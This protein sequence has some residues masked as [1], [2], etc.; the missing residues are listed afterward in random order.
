MDGAGD[1]YT[2]LELGVLD[3][4]PADQYYPGL[5]HLVNAAF[6]HVPEDGDIHGFLGKADDIQSRQGLAAHGVNVAQGIGDGNL[7]ELIGIVDDWREEIDRLDDS[8]VFGK[9]IYA[10]VLRS[11]HSGDEIGVGTEGQ[12][13][14]RLGEVTRTYLASSTRAMNGLGE[15]QLL[16]IGHSLTPKKLFYNVGTPSS[17]RAST[18]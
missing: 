3:G 1:R 17:S 15:T 2:V 10:G 18:L 5:V 14:Q 16:F 13:G 6:E 7:A 9:L 11:L 4:M 8:Q 12:A